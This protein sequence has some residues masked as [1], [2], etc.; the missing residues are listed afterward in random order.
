MRF[1]GVSFFVAGVSLLAGLDSFLGAGGAACFF[2]AFGLGGGFAFA[3]FFG[4]A[5]AGFA[6][7]GLV[8]GVAVAFGVGFC[9][10]SGTIKSVAG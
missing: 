7:A 10:G 4:C 1:L 8:V 9:I 6:G 5:L 2:G 3:V